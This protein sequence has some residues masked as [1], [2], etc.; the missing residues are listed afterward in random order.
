MRTL[1]IDLETYSNVDI[2]KAGLYK[3]AENCEILL[4]AYAF[5]DG[6]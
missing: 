1:A 6:S 2:K 5:D 3:Y 4:V